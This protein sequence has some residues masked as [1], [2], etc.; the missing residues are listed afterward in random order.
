[1]AHDEK[2][3]RGGGGDAPGVRMTAPA[4]TPVRRSPEAPAPF[5]HGPYVEP[6]PA[7]RAPSDRPDAL[8]Q[9]RTVGGH[10]ARLRVGE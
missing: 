5:A 10:T 1:M 8:S 9:P 3:R 2:M 7:P 6:V 4:G